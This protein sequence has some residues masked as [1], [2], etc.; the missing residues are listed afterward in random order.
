M[1]LLEIADV[2][3]AL[4]RGSCRPELTIIERLESGNQEEGASVERKLPVLCRV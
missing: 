2:F 1:N 4:A 3:R